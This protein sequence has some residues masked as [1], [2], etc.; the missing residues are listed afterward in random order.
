MLSGKDRAWLRA[1]LQEQGAKISN[2]WLLTVDM[3]DHITF[4]SREDKP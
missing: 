3:E 1:V 2:T 4:V